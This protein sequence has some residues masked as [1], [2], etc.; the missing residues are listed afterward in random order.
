MKKYKNNCYCYYRHLCR[1]VYF[2]V[3]L[4]EFKVEKRLPLT[5]AEKEFLNLI[6]DNEEYLVN[7]ERN[8]YDE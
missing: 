1:I 8:D 2:H 7:L 6:V 3:K 5:R 4:I